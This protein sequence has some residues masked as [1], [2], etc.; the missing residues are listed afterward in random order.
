VYEERNRTVEKYLPWIE[1]EASIA[2]RKYGSVDESITRD[3]LVN[4]AVVCSID[5]IDRHGVR[6]TGFFPLN[7]TVRGAMKQL[8]IGTHG[9][10]L[11][12]E[13]K[14]KPF[15]DEEHSAGKTISLCLKDAI[16]K[17]S[18]K[19]RDAIL[20]QYYGG[21]SGEE[22]AEKLDVCNGYA[23]QLVCDGLKTIHNLLKGNIT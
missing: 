19:N 5:A 1:K 12:E 16:M 4:T 11:K 18:K 7:R 10:K 3:D 15:I 8:L 2:I 9:Q 14:T 23:R 21:F 6:D 22:I 13:Y 20:L 17:L